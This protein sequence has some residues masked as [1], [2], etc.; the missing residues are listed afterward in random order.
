MVDIL[1]STFPDYE[2]EGHAISGNKDIFKWKVLFTILHMALPVS[3]VYI[4]IIW[5]RKKIVQKL[6]GHKMSENTKAMHKQ[7]LNV[8]LTYRS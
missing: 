6:N 1:H 5:F 7:L 3:P 2:L 8:R 4:A